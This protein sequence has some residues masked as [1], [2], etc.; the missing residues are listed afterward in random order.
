[1]LH[2]IR[3]FASVMLFVLA[4]TV[5][6]LCVAAQQVPKQIQPPADVQLLL[7]VHAKGDQVYT[8]KSD[9]AQFTWQ[10]FR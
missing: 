2:S 4:S 1:M 10:I 8:C 3:E 7:Q 9:A 6:S 5:F